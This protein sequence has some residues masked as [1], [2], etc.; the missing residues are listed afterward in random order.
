MEEIWCCKSDNDK[1]KTYRL[2]DEVKKQS[3]SLELERNKRVNAAR[4]FKNSEADLSKAREKL[5]EMTKARDSAE[6]SLAIA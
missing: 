3:K 2:E 1:E 6:S 5:K 4:T